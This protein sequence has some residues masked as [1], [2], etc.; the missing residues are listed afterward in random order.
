MK[1]SCSVFQT[2]I[3]AAGLGWGWASV[4]A[5]QES[6]SRDFPPPPPPPPPFV[7]DGG[8]ETGGDFAP[9]ESVTSSSFDGDS[10]FS[11]SYSP[12]LFG[13]SREGPPPSVPNVLFD[14]KPEAG[15]AERCPV[16]VQVVDDLVPEELLQEA[17]RPE[18]SPPPSVP[19]AGAPQSP[20]RQAAD[21]GRNQAVDTV[22]SSAKAN[23]NAKGHRSS[24]ASVPPAP[25]HS[26]W[27]EARLEWLVESF[28]VV[29]RSPQEV[30]WSGALTSDYAGCKATGTLT[31]GFR[32]RRAVPG[33]R[34]SGK[35]RQP[36]ARDHLTLVLNGESL[37]LKLNVQHMTG[38]QI[39]DAGVES[40]QP[41]WRWVHRE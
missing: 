17:A 12:G 15:S 39:V 33:R 28:R 29:H 13:Q 7:P 20:E 40:G 36:S 30:V 41:Y 23:E 1:R 34:E 24:S 14:I 38:G 21:R 32:S 2:V 35:P 16:L 3:L 25:I 9:S 11:G 18:R 6:G 31:T 19:R 26:Y 22:P 37:T 10:P 27:G 4:A 5:A 8:G